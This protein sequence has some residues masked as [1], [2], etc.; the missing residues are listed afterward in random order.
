MPVTIKLTFAAGRYHATPWG[1]HVNEGVPEWPPSPWR[2]LRALVA[3]WKRTCADVSEAQ[4]RRILEA[5]AQ[6]PCFQLPPH[7]VA[8]TRHY[9]PLGQKSPREMTGGGTTLVF[10][11]FVSVSRN[12]PLYIGWRDV[13]LPAQ[14]R[15]VLGKLLGNLSSL[16]RAEGWVQAELFDDAVEL[17]I[18]PAAETDL[19]P[20][21]VICPDPS[22]AF[23]AQH[24]PVLDAKK[25]A[26][27]KINPKE[28]LFDCP[29]WH[30]CLDTE[31]I[32]A[33]RWPTVPGSRW[34]NYSR[35]PEATM[36]PATVSPPAVRTHTVARFRLDAAVL[37]LVTDTLPW[38]EAVRS[39][40]LRLRQSPA[41]GGKDAAGQPLQEHRHA[42]FLPSDEDD[43]GRLDHL[44][45]VAERGF[46][47]ADLTALQRLRRV[48]RQDGELH[49]VLVG[50]G[51]PGDFPTALFGPSDTWV[52]ATPYVATRYPKRRGQKRD[53]PADCATPQQFAAA[54][55]RRELARRPDLP[56]CTVELLAG[57][58]RR[59]QWRTLQFHRFRVKSGDDGGRRPAA[60][61]RLTFAR[62]V[63]GPIC[64]GHSAHFGL[65][66]FV[67][68]HP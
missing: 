29:R 7:R 61:L 39:T 56:P 2:L 47:P 51:A 66:L 68:E 40:L 30:L 36:T 21:P 52:S 43:D 54:N 10:D 8:H 46:D 65:G 14:D 15:E 58:G 28:Y 9:M 45:L 64:L 4:V 3:V 35:P 19:N 37:P 12:A 25:L 62:P 33:N 55:L 22:T 41:L 26:S 49:L 42:Y 6:P 67:P 27:G 1:R 31:T 60:A 20:V 5:L 24:Y 11:T 13:D 18:G 23:S 63:A 48:H 50:L 53:A 44:T 57:S 32:H 16:G 59:Q 38:A 34:V 17:P